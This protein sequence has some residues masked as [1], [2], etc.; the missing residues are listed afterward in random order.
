MQF[1]FWEDDVSRKLASR[2]GYASILWKISNA[3]GKF[4]FFLLLGGICLILAVTILPSLYQVMIEPS[5]SAEASPLLEPIMS[6][7]P[8]LA[9]LA[10]IAGG[11]SATVYGLS[12]AL[13]AFSFGDGMWG[14]AIL[15]L[16][17]F[18]GFGIFLGVY[19]KQIKAK[20]ILSGKP[21][22]KN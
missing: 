20:E 18:T 4:A 8:V 19:Y 10:I 7:F 21:N 9:M 13:I 15:A 11:L 22:S 14:A 6:I 17:I 3:S 2:K 16:S 12:A 5:S 1:N